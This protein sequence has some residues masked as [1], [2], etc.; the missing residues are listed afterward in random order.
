[1]LKP[2]L[3]A[4]RSILKPLIDSISLVKP[5][6]ELFR[7]GFSAIAEFIR[8]ESVST[9]GRL[10]MGALLLL[11]FVLVLTIVAPAVIERVIGHF[12]GRMPPDWTALVP[13]GAF[14]VLALVTVVSVKLIPPDPPST[15]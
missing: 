8:S 14:I 3:T 13:I 1:V 11:T 2:V 7:P 6:A 5:V 9:P 12:T 10:N 15:P 4:M